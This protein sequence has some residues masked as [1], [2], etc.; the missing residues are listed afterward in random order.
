A[1]TLLW[2]EKWTPKAHGIRAAAYAIDRRLR[3][4][5]RIATATEL[6]RS[7]RD[8]NPL[9]RIVVDDATARE[10]S[11]DPRA[12]HPRR[13]PPVLLLALVLAGFAAVLQ[14]APVTEFRPAGLM[15]TG[16]A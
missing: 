2:A 5:E 8:L 4:G 12:V 9:E 10:P 13:W 11:I 14:L 6:S 1:V 7:G 16:A 15:V 3:L